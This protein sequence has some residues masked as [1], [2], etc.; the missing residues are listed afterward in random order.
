[1]FLISQINASLFSSFT[2]SVLEI[3]N[4]FYG[5]VIFFRH[6][7]HQI[8]RLGL[9]QR[10]NRSVSSAL[11]SYRFLKPRFWHTPFNV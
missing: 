10:L 4:R 1:M 9:L 11:G 8:I 6:L 7:L 3:L 2:L 5:A